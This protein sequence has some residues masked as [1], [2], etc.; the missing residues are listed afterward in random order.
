MQFNGAAS[1]R[2]CSGGVTYEWDFGDG[3]T[4]STAEDPAHTYTTPGIYTWKMTASIEGLTCVKSGV[5]T[6]TACSVSCSA[7]AT[8]ASGGAPLQVQFQGGSTT[9]NCSGSVAYDWDFGD[10][11]AH[12]PQQS[13]SHTYAAAGTCNWKLTVT[14]GGQ[15]CTKSGTVTVAAVLA[16]LQCQRFGGR[17][18]P[19]LAVTLHGLRQPRELLRHAD[20]RWDFGD[21]TAH[22]SSAGSHTPTAPWA[23]TPGSSPPASAG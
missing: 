10:G 20:H 4:H 19:P 22:S 15:T 1:P 5:V 6:V 14:A 3:T 18:R 11:S 17:R 9:S 23:S 16:H 21:G 8:P 2:D 7:T 12:S 13:P